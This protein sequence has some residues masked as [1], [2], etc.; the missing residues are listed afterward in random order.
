MRMKVEKYKKHDN[1]AKNE[2]KSLFNPFLTEKTKNLAIKKRENLNLNEL[3]EKKTKTTN[4]M[5]KQYEE[6]SFDEFNGEK[7]IQNDREKEKKL[8][9]NQYYSSDNN[10][11]S[12]VNNFSK[13][14]KSLK[15]NYKF[16]DEHNI[17]NEEN[18]KNKKKMLNEIKYNKKN[19]ENII[20]IIKKK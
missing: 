6:S 17:N 3:A 10:E 18:E 1:I 7:T 19:H 5:E 9:R 12:Y 15:R 13:N 2:K 4:G 11:K 8:K 20:S 14:D 16:G